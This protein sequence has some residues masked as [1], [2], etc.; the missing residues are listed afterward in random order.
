MELMFWK[1]E[2]LKP[3][4][5]FVEVLNNNIIFPILLIPSVLE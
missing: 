1:K 2:K 4:Y 5:C 3:I